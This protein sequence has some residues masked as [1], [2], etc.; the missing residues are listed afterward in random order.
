MASLKFYWPL[1]KTSLNNKEIPC[2]PAVLEDN[3]YVRDFK[4]K[5]ELFN[6]L[7]AKQ[8]FKLDNS[9][10]FPLNYLKK[11]QINLSL[12]LLSLAMILQH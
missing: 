2:I 12:Q 3:K 1:L 4:K 10:E 11:T 5:A 6:L 9:S 7:F 8:Y